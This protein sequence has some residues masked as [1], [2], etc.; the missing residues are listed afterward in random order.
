MEQKKENGKQEKSKERKMEEQRQQGVRIQKGGKAK[1]KEIYYERRTR[2]R[3][4]D[5]KE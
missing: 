5:E 3:K 1:R 4:E 2:G